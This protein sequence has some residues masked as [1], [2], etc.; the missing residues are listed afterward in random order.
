M[1]FTK[2][3]LA[4]IT[5]SVVMSLA[6]FPINAFAWEAIDTNGDGLDDTIRFCDGYESPI[7]K[8]Q[9]HDFWDWNKVELDT[10]A[11]DLNDDFCRKNPGAQQRVD[12]LIP[13]EKEWE[14]KL[15]PII[16]DVIL[17]S[18]SSSN[19]RVEKLNTFLKEVNTRIKMDINAPHRIYPWEV[20]K[21]EFTGNSTIDLHLQGIQLRK[22]S[23]DIWNGNIALN[24]KEH[25][26][27][28]SYLFHQYWQEVAYPTSDITTDEVRIV[29]P[30]NRNLLFFIDGQWWELKYSY[31]G[32]QGLTVGISEETK[33]EII[34]WPD[35]DFA[36]TS[37]SESFQENCKNF[38]TNLPQDIIEARKAAGRYVPTY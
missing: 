15:Q 13:I 2:M 14:N 34:N 16:D 3:I 37:S 23:Y 32:L 10:K 38:W 25:A 27:F 31:E 22:M 35:S 30:Y 29:R 7:E 36:L 6:M 24:E 17:K 33:N 26:L 21:S 8:W 4:T 28:I 11:L 18:K 19:N 9:L 5:S 20:D 1:R 12:E